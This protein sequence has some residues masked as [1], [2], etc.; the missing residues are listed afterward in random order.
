MDDLDYKLQHYDELLVVLISKTN[1]L[2]HEIKIGDD[3]EVSQDI[4]NYL[5]DGI[6]H[7]EEL[8]EKLKILYDVIKEN[9]ERAERVLET[10][11]NI[12]SLKQRIQHLTR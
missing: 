1:A 7:M 8:A 12:T 9:D 10:M 4:L 11:D 6:I 3:N 2:E 5:Q